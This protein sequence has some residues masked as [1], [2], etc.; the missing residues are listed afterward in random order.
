M[1]LPQ[2]VAFG[3]PETIRM[4]WDR[5]DDEERV[6]NPELIRLAIDFHH[7]EVARWLLQEQPL[8]L[9]IGRLFARETRAFD[10]LSRLPK[11][12]AELPTLDDVSRVG[13]NPAFDGAVA[14]AVEMR[15]TSWLAAALL[16]G[17]DSSGSVPHL[18]GVREAALC[19]AARSGYE[20]GVRLL[21]QFGADPNKEGC[22]RMSALAVGAR[23][24]GIVTLLLGKGA[25]PNAG[26]ASSCNNPLACA[27]L[28]KNIESLR[29][30]FA[31]DGDASRVDS[32]GGN[33]LH[34]ALEETSA[35]CCRELLARGAD[36]CGRAW[37][38]DETPMH[39]VARHAFWDDGPERVKIL[40]L[41]LEAGAW[42]LANDRWGATPGDTARQCIIGRAPNEVLEWFARH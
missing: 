17:G 30:M 11:G 12:S 40:D 2:A 25:K 7:V 4:V 23:Y 3:D 35:E 6:S 20:E 16:A 1:T 34:V 26:R 5:S 24:P 28:A 21:L 18:P 31:Y 27:A 38:S 9:D 41:L 15:S 13:R 14:D 37:G 33:V 36:P 39:V 29:L 22:N 10:V 42:P 8:W 19:H 32:L